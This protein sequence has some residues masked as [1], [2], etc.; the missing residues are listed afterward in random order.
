MIFA[1]ALRSAQYDRNR[2]L[3]SALRAP[4]EMTAMEHKALRETKV[5]VYK[6]L[7]EMKAKVRRAS[8]E[9]KAKM[10]KASHET[11]VKV[12]PSISSRAYISTPYVFSNVVVPMPPRA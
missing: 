9:M 8:H 5:K 11:K 4:L 12:C 6:A 7:H 2:F 1:C 10:H 3:D